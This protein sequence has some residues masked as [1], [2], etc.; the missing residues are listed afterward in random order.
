MLKSEN[1]VKEYD[2]NFDYIYDEN[3][4]QANV[5]QEL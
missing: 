5:F 2:F 1:N 4:T 3:A